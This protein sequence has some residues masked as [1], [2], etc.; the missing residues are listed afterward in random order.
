MASI[1]EFANPKRFMNLSGAIL[2]WLTA[3]CVLS[4]AV[5]LYLG[6]AAPPDYQQGETV[7]R[8]GAW[9]ALL[10]APTLVA[11]WY[12]MNFAHMPELA[13]RHSYWILIGAVA[14][15]CLVLYAMFKRAKWL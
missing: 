1:F 11:S 8:L 2:P 13:G 7:K 5:G 4:L 10:A 6:F 9:A 12:G 14:V 15:I 3:I